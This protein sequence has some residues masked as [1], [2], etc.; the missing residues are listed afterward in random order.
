MAR[1]TQ[2]VAGPITEPVPAAT[3]GRRWSLD[4][5]GS[6]RFWGWAAPLLVMLIGGFQR[7]W[8]LDW[9]HELVFDE[10]YYV[11]EGASYLRYGYEQALKPIPSGSP[12]PFTL[13]QHSVFGTAG[14]FVVH[15]PVGKWMITGG[16]WVFGA[17][18]SWGW[19][20]SAAVVGTL[21]I[22]I[23][24]RVSRRLFGSTTLGAIAA[25]LLAVDGQEFVH[26]RT[27]LLDIFVMFWA[28]AAF[29][30]LVIDRD[31][32]R[33]R[34]AS[35]LALPGANRRSGPWLGVRGWRIAA[36]VC[37]GLDVGVKW[38]GIYFAVAFLAA[39]ALWDCSARRAAGV[40][41]WVLGAAVLDGLQAFG[42][43]VVLIPA[44][45]LSSWAG[46]FATP[47][48]WDR[49]WA[50]QHAAE[51][52]WRWVPD[53]ARSL[54]HYHAEMW[55]FHL[56]LHTPHPY[57]SNPW[58]WLVLGRPTAFFYEKHAAGQAGCHVVECSQAI[59]PLG[60]P[61]IWWGG[62]LAIGVLLFRWALARDWRAGAVLAGLVGGYLPW[63][64]YQERTIF[65]FYAVAFVPWVVLAVTYCLGLILGPSQA[66]P[67]RRRIGALVTG[68]YV[69]AALMLFWFFYPILSAE[70]IPRG[71]WSVRMWL[72][73]WI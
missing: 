49:Q 43:S 56:T 7:F 22:L 9:P 36:I 42:T 8:H 41:H 63:F 54:L 64:L 34:L 37:L 46:W 70:V 67:E 11:K 13:G 20:F 23:I 71:A 47:G 12:D 17:D 3:V 30:C 48:G 16:E 39:S 65:S 58:S 59:T 1:V 24:G 33:A 4:L 29:A 60:N 5:A 52:G 66:P 10:V 15:P 18:S 51:P 25:L 45:Y 50:A 73:G 35:R 62:T 32:A 57:Q 14:D 19:R 55:H 31:Q 68:S 21:S 61:A 2:T 6:D 28:L 72:P 38:S 53:I 69:F 44:V 27:G 26:S 40:R